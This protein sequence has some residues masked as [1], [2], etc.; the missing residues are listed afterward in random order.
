MEAGRYW[1]GTKVVRASQA[2]WSSEPSRSPLG[3]ILSSHPAQSVLCGS[4]SLSLQSL[5]FVIVLLIPQALSGFRVSP[6]AFWEWEN[7]HSS[8]SVGLAAPQAPH[9]V[10]LGPLLLRFPL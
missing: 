10:L 7:V 4:L 5:E 9:R 8:L 3:S 1:E 2:W 6:P